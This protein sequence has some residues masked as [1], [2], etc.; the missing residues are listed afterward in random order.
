MN[1]HWQFALAG[2]ICAVPVWYLLASP[3]DSARWLHAGG[4]DSLNY[5]GSGVFGGFFFWL[6]LK[7]RRTDAL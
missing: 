2:L 7:V 4:F 5:L 1:K 3:F 6:L